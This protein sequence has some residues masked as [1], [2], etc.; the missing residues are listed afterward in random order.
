MTK[1][2]SNQMQQMAGGVFVA[3]A[4]AVLTSPFVAVGAF[5][6]QIY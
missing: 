2:N 3:L 4:A 6:L 1:L 5:F